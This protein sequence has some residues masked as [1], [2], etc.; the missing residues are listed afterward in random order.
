MS[1]II[2]KHF[3]FVEN[4]I[5]ILSDEKKYQQ[6]LSQLEG[7]CELIIKKRER[8]RSSNQN[9]YWHGVVLPLIAEEMCLYP[10]ETKEFLKRRFLST[11]IKVKEKI[12]DIVKRTSSLSTIE[13][14]EFVKRCQMFGAKEL[15][16]NIPDPNEIEL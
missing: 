5:L 15:G 13:F 11:E 6:W 9:K 8:L 1:K 3:C 7:E 10:D 16:L 2:P 4:G 14:N 12:Y